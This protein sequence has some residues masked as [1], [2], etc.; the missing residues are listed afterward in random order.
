[1][2]QIDITVEAA[3][4][5]AED[6]RRAD[7]VREWLRRDELAEEIFDMLDA[8]GK[9]VSF[10]EIIW[11]MS[12][13]Q[14]WPARLEYRDPRWFTFDRR[15]LRQP[16]LRGGIDGSGQPEPLPPFKFITTQIKAKSGLPVRG[17]IARLAAWAW[18]F[19]A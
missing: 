6:V 14:F 8:I 18:M 12:A 17:G 1:M 15:T 9:G 7:I 16:L 4:E 19:K 2:A 5:D 10:T 13:G 3:S 11:D